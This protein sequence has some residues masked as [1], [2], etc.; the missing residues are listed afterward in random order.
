MNP[1]INVLL[2]TKAE[3]IKVAPVI[4]ELENRGVPFRLIE[5]GQ[6]G[7]YLNE[8]REEF[9]IREP[10]VRL[11]KEKDVD[12]L[13]EAFKWFGGLIR[14]LANRKRVRKQIF[15]APSG[16]CLIHGDTPSTLI[17]A[18]LAKRAG[19]Q[20][21]H[22]ESGLRSKSFLHP[23]PEE[24]IRVAVMKLSDVLFAPDEKAVSNLLALKVKGRIEQTT[25]NTGI[26]S[27][28][29][30]IQEVERASGPV[31]ATLHRVENLHNKKRLEGFLKLLERIVQKGQK[32]LFVVHQPTQEVLNKKGSIKK[33]EATGIEMVSLM[34]YKEFI[35]KLA[36][37]P[38]VITDGG[39]I[40]EETAHMGIPCLL[41]RRKTER[42][43][44][45][46]Q[47]V[48]ISEYNEKICETFLDNFENY[49]NE[50]QKI[51][52]N[53]SSHVVDVLEEINQTI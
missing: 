36:A 51:S 40:Q 48:V 37:A 35:K 18:L 9:Q 33:I 27:L 17:G 32:V 6:H 11:G 16:I 4:K 22:L 3:M 42:K 38:Y 21:A 1:K 10:D 13:F 46:D 8:L 26:E 25:T 24:L 15:S 14:I 53:P 43:N 5:T 31:V 47:N 20:I 29:E 28:E 30:N 39:S 19:F 45:L 41:W 23:F 7:A 52:L 49:R 44:G 2:G 50:N 34:Q 12:N